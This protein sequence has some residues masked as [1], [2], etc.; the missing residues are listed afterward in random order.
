MVV[1]LWLFLEIKGYFAEKTRSS[2][3]RYG[4]GHGS[5]IFQ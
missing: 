4:H 2:T 5:N 3:C 1:I